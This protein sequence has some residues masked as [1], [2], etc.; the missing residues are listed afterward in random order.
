MRNARTFRNAN[1]ASGGTLHDDEPQP[2]QRAP[3]RVNRP[4][5]AFG[6]AGCLAGWATPVNGEIWPGSTWTTVP[7]AQVSMDPGRTEAVRDFG[8][9]RGGSGIITRWARRVA[10]WGDQRRKYDLK[11]TTKSF[12]SILTALAF[13]DRPSLTRNSLVKPILPEIVQAQNTTQRKNWASA[14]EV[15]HL[16]THAAGYGKVGGYTNLEFAPGTAWRYSDGGTNWLAD[17]MTVVYGADL[18]TVLRQ[19]VLAPLGISNDRLNWR[20]NR[21]RSGSLRGITRREF[22]SGI[23]TD[24]D[25]MARI[26]VMLLRDGRWNNRQILRAEDV[27]RASTHRDWLARLPCRGDDEQLR[28][29]SAQQFLRFPILDQQ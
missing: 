8:Q 21:Y 4:W 3:T 22:G 13:K 7:A 1:K 24:V 29:A 20:T 16:L 15:R 19:R 9:D 6:L 2:V 26:G 28:A 23:S 25:V 12:G 17:L 14:I 27:E 10:F 5:L 18:Q 11:S